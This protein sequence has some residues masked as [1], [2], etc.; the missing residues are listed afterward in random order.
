MQTVEF[1]YPSPVVRAF[2][3]LAYGGIVDTSLDDNELEELYDLCRYRMCSKRAAAVGTVQH[4]RLTGKIETAHERRAQEEE[5]ADLGLK[6]FDS[7]Q[8]RECFPDM[9]IVTQGGCQ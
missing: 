9:E 8:K 7:T 5:A 4:A 2:V 3:D 6:L 1:D